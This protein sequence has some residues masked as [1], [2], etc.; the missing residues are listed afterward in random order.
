MEEGIENNDIAIGTLQEEVSALKESGGVEGFSPIATVEDTEEG[1]VITITD[2]SGTTT[3]TV[4][5]GVG[6]ARVYLKTPGIGDG[7]TSTYVVEL[8]DGTI[9]L[10]FNIKNG[11][12]GNG[13][14]SAT[15]N[16]DYT[17]TLTFDDDTS[18]TTPS[19][20]GETPVK[21]EDYFTNS[22]KEELVAQ[23]KASLPTI[24]MIGVDADGV[25]HTFT[26]Y[27]E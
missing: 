11:N 13:I 24:T 21:G 3:A 12:K 10:T 15:L 25:S 16:D 4:K 20:R 22:D 8:T 27:G 5:D 26:L 7:A 1:A 18:Y 17:L 2:K 6:I 23:V 19:I 14:K 9:A